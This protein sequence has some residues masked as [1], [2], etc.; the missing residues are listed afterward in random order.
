MDPLHLGDMSIP[1]APAAPA[2]SADVLGP[3]RFHSQLDRVE[4][5]QPDRGARPS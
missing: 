2:I 5:P 4:S 1:V 3:K